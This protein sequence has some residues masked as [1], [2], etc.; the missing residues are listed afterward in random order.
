MQGKISLDIEQNFLDTMQY[1]FNDPD[2]PQILSEIQTPRQYSTTSDHQNAIFPIAQ[3]FVQDNIPILQ[4]IE[5]NKESTTPLEH[6]PKKYKGVRRRPWGK[7]AAEIRDPERKGCR[8][9]LGTYE[10]PEDAA[11]AYDRTAFKLR[12]SRAVLNFPHLIESNVTEINRVRP[13][14]RPRS[15]EFSS[16]SSPPPPRYVGDN[17]NESNNNNTD[18]PSSKRR[19]VELIN[20]LATVN[21]LDGQNIMERCLTSNYYFA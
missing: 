2:F 3:N 16:S 12:G 8:L 5:E 9:W 20:S 13:R 15:P 17:N 7:Y 4:E 6:R 1:L 18:R 11:L 19:N 10:T 14:R 21:N